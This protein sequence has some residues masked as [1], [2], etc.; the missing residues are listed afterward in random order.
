M[1]KG[2]LMY[3]IDKGTGKYKGY[4][5]FDHNYCIYQNYIDYVL[6]YY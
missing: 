6:E 5:L 3:I 2:Q 1:F 4:G